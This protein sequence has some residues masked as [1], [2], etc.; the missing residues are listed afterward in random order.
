MILTVT[1]DYVSCTVHVE[2]RI[3]IVCNVII[4]TCMYLSSS[5]LKLALWLEKIANFEQRNYCYYHY[6]WIAGVKA[7]VK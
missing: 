1:V 5:Y 3:F 2:F 7:A 6:I 4:V